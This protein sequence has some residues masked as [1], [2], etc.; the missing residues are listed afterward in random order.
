[1]PDLSKFL[2]RINRKQKLAGPSSHDNLLDFQWITMLNSATEL[3]VDNYFKQFLHIF[4]CVVGLF[5]FGFF[6]FFCSIMSQDYVFLCI[7]S[8]TQGIHGFYGEANT[9]IHISAQKLS[10]TKTNQYSGSLQ[11]NHHFCAVHV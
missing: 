1:M 4:F 7:F 6:G 5:G 9:T 2:L 8:K 3:N 10:L 11:H